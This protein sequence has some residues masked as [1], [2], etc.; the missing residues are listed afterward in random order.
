[1]NF[2]KFAVIS[3][4]GGLTTFAILLSLVFATGSTFGQRCSEMGYTGTDHRICVTALTKG[5]E[6]F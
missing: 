5:E 1:M 6:D 3:V 4:I 2:E